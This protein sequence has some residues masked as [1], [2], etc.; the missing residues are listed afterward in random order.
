[1]KRLISLFSTLLMVQLGLAT[2]NVSPSQFLIA[3]DMINKPPAHHDLHLQAPNGQQSRV[4]ILGSASVEYDVQVSIV[5]KGNNHR[6]EKCD[7]Q[8]GQV[9]T[10]EIPTCILDFSEQNEVKKILLNSAQA[11][12]KSN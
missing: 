11:P 5:V 10:G 2:T 1:M 12:E 3:D 7:F 6:Q 4:I 9:P 8:F